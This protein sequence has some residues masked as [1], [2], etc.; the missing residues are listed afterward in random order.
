MRGGSWKC[1][2]ASDSPRHNSPRRLGRPAKPSSISRILKAHGIPPVPERPTSWQTFLRAHWGA[3]AGA[4]FF[5]TEVWTWRGLV[6]YYT[7][8][9]IDLASRRVHIVGSTA[10]PH[11]V[12]MH[13]VARTLTTADDGVLR[14]HRVLICDRDTK[15]SASVRDRLGEAGICVVQ[16]PY[17]A[18][19][20]N[21][22][23][24]RFVR[25]IKEECLDQLIPDRRAP[26]PTGDHG[27]CRALS[28]RAQ[29][30]RSGERVDRGRA[31]DQHRRPDSSASAFG[32]IT[33]L[34]RSRG[35]SVGSA[36]R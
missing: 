29:S 16:T 19:K 22:Y 3:I 8:F 28:S 21:A 14:H 26:L 5:T 17:Q 36:G 33:Q 1:V 27:I 13:Q 12:F 32:W 9:V 2:D 20:A 31:S 10:H 23:A 15:W 11:G 4:D 35:V 6:T 25:S 30:P 18:P 7:V 34:L 24:E